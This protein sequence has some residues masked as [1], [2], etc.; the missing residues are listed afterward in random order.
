MV[1][2]RARARVG[3]VLRAKWRLD[4]LLG[5]GGMAAVYA[6]T[7]RNG[8]RGAVKMLHLELSIDDDARTRFLREGYVANKVDHLGAVSVLDDDVAEDGSVFL[9]MELLEGET[10]EERAQGRPGARLPANEVVW[11]ADQLLDVLAA[12]HDKGIVHRDLKPENLFVT[13]QG[14][15]KVLDFGIA[16]LRELTGAS[17][18][19]RTGSMM[20]TPTFMPPEQALGNWDSVDGRTDLWAVGA[21]MFSLLTGATVHEADTVN[22]LL[23]LAMTKPARPISSVIPSLP[24]PLAAVVDRALAFD[25]KDR[26]ADAR[27][28]QRALR[29]AG[30]GTLATATVA[31]RAPV[32][33]LPDVSPASYTLPSPGLVAPASSVASR[34]LITAPTGLSRT[35]VGRRSRVGAPLAIG[36]AAVLT[37]GGGAAALLFGLPRGTAAPDSSVAVAAQPP[38]GPEPPPVAEPLPTAVPEAIPE[39]PASSAEPAP[40]AASTP[41]KPTVAA[42]PPATP[43]PPAT[44]TPRPPTKPPKKDPFD[45]F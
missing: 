36:A 37:L 17:N 41:P 7:H 22:K 3:H 26:W 18:A 14:E 5:V 11:I 27:A 35:T 42:R 6:A 25:Q 39:P 30:A 19:T 8:K 4:R 15:L 9:V 33:S 32:A 21:T 10:T 31:P 23:L 34:S 24:A 40:P 13:R 12:A 38:A 45:R 43:R 28:M 44:T 16:R 2:V 29:E 1:T 20:G